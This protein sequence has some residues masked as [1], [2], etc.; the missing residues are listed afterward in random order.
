MMYRRLLL[1]QALRMPEEESAAIA[2][3]ASP[4]RKQHQHRVAEALKQHPEWQK[5]QAWKQRI[6]VSSCHRKHFHP[7][8]RLM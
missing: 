2:A 6:K 5:V 8:S 3:Q 4:E 7:S 1:M